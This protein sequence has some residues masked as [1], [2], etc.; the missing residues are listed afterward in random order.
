MKV[1][2]MEILKNIL[3]LHSENVPIN[4]AGSSF[5]EIVFSASFWRH[6]IFFVPLL[7]FS[8]IMVVMLFRWTIPDGIG[9]NF[10]LIVMVVITGIIYTLVLIATGLSLWLLTQLYAEKALALDIIERGNDQLG[11]IK[12]KVIE[13]PSLDDLENYIPFKAAHNRRLLAQV[14]DDIYREARD[15]VFGSPN[16][17]L[18][19]YKEHLYARL[20]WLNGIQTIALR[21]GILGTFFGLILVVIKAGT[22]TNIF[23]TAPQTNGSIDINKVLIMLMSRQ[24]D[25]KSILD[26][27]FSALRGAFGTSVAGLEVSIIV[28]IFLLYLHVKQD[29]LFHKLDEATNVI[30]HLLRNALNQSGLLSSFDQMKESMKGLERR[31][32]SEFDGVSRVHK[33][34]SEKISEQVEVTENG[35]NALR[36]AKDEWNK[37][38]EAIRTAHENVLKD[39]TQLSQRGQD[40]FSGFLAQLNIAQLQFIDEAKATLDLLSVGRLGN[41]INASIRQTGESISVSLGKEINSVVDHLEGYF[42]TLQSVTTISNT[43]SE[44]LNALVLAISTADTNL[45]VI[46]QAPDQFKTI[47]ERLEQAQQ[48]FREAVQNAYATAAGNPIGEALANNLKQL[49]TESVAPIVKSLNDTNIQLK[50]L[51]KR[52]QSL[53]FTTQSVA[54]HMPR[55]VMHYVAVIIGALAVLIIA[56]FGYFI[57]T[58]YYGVTFNRIF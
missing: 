3:S 12:G 50:S 22:A 27:L 46:V 34:L 13:P 4:M 48:G 7:V 17:I 53:D 55:P 47:M 23:D 18:Q 21:L 40:K 2:I 11:K 52:I 36:E 1:K 19:P 41:T 28:N 35:L 38:V 37:F 58:E 20:G 15:A 8:M 51:E 29:G 26:G 43:L 44:R 32:R 45:K 25:F 30:F 6:N 57:S 54:S 31:M 14:Y 39:M 24:H 16:L 42:V 56:F 33:E 5:T 49:T 9:T 10:G